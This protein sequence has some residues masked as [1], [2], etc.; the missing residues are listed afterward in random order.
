MDKNNDFST[1]EWIFNCQ[2]AEE[3]SKKVFKFFENS[4]FKGVAV[5]GLGQYAMTISSLANFDSDYID[6]YLKNNF[7]DH[8]HVV[9]HCSKYDTPVH[10]QDSYPYH[11]LSKK[12]QQIISVSADFNIEHGIAIPVSGHKGRGLVSLDFDG[13]ASELQKYLKSNLFSLIGFCQAIMW[14]ASSDF[15]NLIYEIPKLTPR[16]YECLKYLSSGLS[17]PEIARLISVSINRVKELVASLL[18]KLHA[19]NRTELVMRAITQ[20][21]I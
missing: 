20:G 19:A 4:G 6:I 1:M 10:W 18:K 16:E 11:T 13:S 9:A 7:K 21:L 3:F 2:K 15:S 17:N 5:G 14:R 12:A 8:D